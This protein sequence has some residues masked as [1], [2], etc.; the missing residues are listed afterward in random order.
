MISF[1]LKLALL[2]SWSF[3]FFLPLASHAGTVKASGDSGKGKGSISFGVDVP[4]WVVKKIFAEDNSFQKI[5]P[6]MMAWK[7]LSRSE[8]KLLGDCTMSISPMLPPSRYIAE[9]TY[10]SASKI[11]F[12]RKRGD[13]KDLRGD[14][15][16]TPKG[17]NYTHFVYSFSV[18]TGF[19]ILPGAAIA[20]ELRKHLNATEQKVT[21]YT[22][23]YAKREQAKAEH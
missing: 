20:M 13:L 5:I 2:C 16:I 22:R 11:S 3:L 12:Q 15:V 8:N 1:S 23:A 6:G 9:V 10:H 7:V 14:W 19:A 4:F 21:I 17:E 18:D